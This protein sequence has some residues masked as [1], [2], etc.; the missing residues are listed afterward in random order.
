MIAELEPEVLKL[1][2]ETYIKKYCKD[3][4]TARQKLYELGLLDVHGNIHTNYK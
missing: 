2:C 3:K 4:E 1:V